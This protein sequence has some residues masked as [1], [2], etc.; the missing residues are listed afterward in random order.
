MLTSSLPM[1]FCNKIVENKP[2][3]TS[4]ILFKGKKYVLTSMLERG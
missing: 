3:K 4:F 1:Y 2:A